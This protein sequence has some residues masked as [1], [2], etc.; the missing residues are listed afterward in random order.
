MLRM[1]TGCPAAILQ[2]TWG[3][4]ISTLSFAFL[5]VSQ[6]RCCIFIFL[7]PALFH[8]R[9]KEEVSVSAVSVGF[10]LVCGCE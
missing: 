5:K 8:E 4:K 6:K 9:F 1:S 3:N 2:K 10:P 7:C